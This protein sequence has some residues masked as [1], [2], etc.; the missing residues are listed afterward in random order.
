MFGHH[1][2]KR[3]RKEIKRD[4][5][6]LERE[7]SMFEAQKPELERQNEERIQSQIG[8]N[9]EAAKNARNKARQEGRAYAEEV[10]SRDVQGLTPAQRNAMQYEAN[11]NIQRAH[12]SANRQLLGEQSRHGIVGKGGVGYAQQRDLQRLANEARG[13]SQRDLDRLNA[14]LALKKLAAMFNIE[15]GEATQSQLDRQL[16][17]DELRLADER[18]RQKHYEDQFNR[19]FSRV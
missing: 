12:Q 11:K 1:K 4:R 8:V 2:R 3:Q 7:R 5:K 9:A 10:I 14:D 16:A 18:R 6:A 17:S 13:Q 15:Q 19:L